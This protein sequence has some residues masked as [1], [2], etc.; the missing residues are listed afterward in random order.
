MRIG[1]QPGQIDLAASIE[2][3]VDLSGPRGVGDQTRRGSPI[4]RFGKH[5]IAEALGRA[6]HGSAADT[7]AFGQQR[8]QPQGI[9]HHDLVLKFRQARDEPVQRL[10]GITPDRAL[11]IDV[12]GRC[13]RQDPGQ[14]W[15]VLG[16]G[17]TG[18]PGGEDGPGEPRKNQPTDQ[19]SVSV[20]QPPALVWILARDHRAVRSKI[21]MLCFSR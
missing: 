3:A 20:A 8:F 19:D 5:G 12:A 7:V 6:E 10:V 15:L 4:D 16:L 14:M 11:S 17:R 2:R 21:T 9:R 13:D 1:Q 18:R